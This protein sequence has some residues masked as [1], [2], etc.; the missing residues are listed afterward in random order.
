MRKSDF[1]IWVFVLL[2]FIA[3]GTSMIN[4]TRS[5]SATAE[6]SEIYRHLDLFGDVL[7]RVRS[8]YVEVAG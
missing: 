2:A 1:A 6:N 7:E 5:Q 4:A 8:D 3:A